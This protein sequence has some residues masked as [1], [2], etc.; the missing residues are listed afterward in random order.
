MSDIIERKLVRI[1]DRLDKY[2]EKV[3]GRGFERVD[4]FREFHEKAT[5]EIEGGARFLKFEMR[6]DLYGLGD[7]PYSFAPYGIGYGGLYEAL[8][9]R[10]FEEWRVD[11]GIDERFSV[12]ALGA[13]GRTDYS[14]LRDR[15]ARSGVYALMKSAYAALLEILGKVLREYAGLASIVSCVFPTMSPLDDRIIKRKVGSEE[16]ACYAPCYIAPGDVPAV[17]VVNFWSGAFSELLESC[18]YDPASGRFE[19]SVSV[20]RGSQ[21]VAAGRGLVQLTIARAGVYFDFEGIEGCLDAYLLSGY[22]PVEDAHR[23]IDEVPSSDEWLSNVKRLD[24]R[25]WE[26]LQQALSSV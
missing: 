14:A 3:E 16:A 17:Q 25:Y 5:R 18:A 21:R 6:L 10:A 13:G 24:E 22:K 19:Y 12:H 9:R 1:A 4:D 8:T 26:K 11:V 7:P 23:L 20:E 15:F 2:R